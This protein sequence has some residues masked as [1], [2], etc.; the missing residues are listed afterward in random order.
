MSFEK[1][2]AFFVKTKAQL[3]IAKS[4]PEMVIVGAPNALIFSRNPSY[5]CKIF[6]W[7]V[8]L[9]VQLLVFGSNFCSL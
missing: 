9:Q 1:K 5:Q 7:L 2:C 3:V 8:K 6:E 4:Q